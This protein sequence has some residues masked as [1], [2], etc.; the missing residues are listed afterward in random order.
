PTT[1]FNLTF[2]RPTLDRSESASSIFFIPFRVELM[3]SRVFPKEF[4]PSRLA[5]GLNFSTVDCSAFGKHPATTSGFDFIFFILYTILSAVAS[6]T[7]Q[8]TIRFKSDSVEFWAKVW[9]PFKIK[10]EIISESAKL[11]EHPYASTQIF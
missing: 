8:V 2:G 10:P 4:G 9:P 1:E 5:F 6:L 7:E 11:A 3:T